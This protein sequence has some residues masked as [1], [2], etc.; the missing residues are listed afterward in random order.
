MCLEEPACWIIGPRFS[1]G[2]LSNPAI[3]IR[4]CKVPNVCL[5]IILHLTLKSTSIWN[6]LWSPLL[7]TIKQI[8]FDLHQRLNKIRWLHWVSNK[9]M[10]CALMFFPFF[11]ID[12]A[13]AGRF[14]HTAH[15]G[16]ISLVVELLAAGVLID[17]V[18]KHVI[19]AFMLA[20][21]S[22]SA[23][24]WPISYISSSKILCISLTPK[25]LYLA[26]WAISYILSIP[27]WIRYPCSR[28]ERNWL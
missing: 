8:G 4:R 19:T 21:Y 24:N 23:R 20:S 6:K 14:L 11:E 1:L 22:N 17:I 15:A 25:N 5:K 16:D 9:S 7:P 10:C 2:I 27:I 18:D 3:Q 28:Q 13:L 26:S 12:Q